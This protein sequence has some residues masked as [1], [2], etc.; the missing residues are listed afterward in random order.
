MP[1]TST[2]HCQSCDG[3]SGPN[4]YRLAQSSESVI[5]N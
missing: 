2:C 5:S 3:A 1:A 4:G